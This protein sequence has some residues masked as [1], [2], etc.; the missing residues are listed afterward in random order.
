ML[1]VGMLAFI[2]IVGVWTALEFE[3]IGQ[4]GFS[5]PNILPLS[6]VP[7][8]AAFFA[9]ACWRGLQRARCMLSPFYSAVALFIITYGCS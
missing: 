7:A 1:L 2:V 8:A 9:W 6:P 3:R 5:W 4:R